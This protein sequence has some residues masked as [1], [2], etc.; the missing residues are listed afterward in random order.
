[1]INVE[2]IEAE[3]AV[4]LEQGHTVPC[5]DYWRDVL[6]MDALGERWDHWSVPSCPVC[7]AR[8][9]RKGLL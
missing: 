6:V 3:R 9:A 5:A 8:R 2:K 4:L 1:M 7:D